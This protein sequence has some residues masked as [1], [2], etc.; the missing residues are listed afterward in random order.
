MRQT[1]RKARKSKGGA[2]GNWF[3]KKNTIKSSLGNLREKLG[4]AS[5]TN[6]QGALRS[7]HINHAEK[8]VVEDFESIADNQNKNLNKSFNDILVEIVRKYTS[9]NLDNISESLDNISEN[10]YQKYNLLDKVKITKR[11][12]SNTK[13]KEG[14][15]VYFIIGINNDVEYKIRTCPKY[16]DSVEIKSAH[17]RWKTGPFDKFLK[18][19]LESFEFNNS[20]KIIKEYLSA[21]DGEIVGRAKSDAKGKKE[22]TVYFI[23]KGMRYE[24]KIR[25]CPDSSYTVEINQDGTWKTGPLDNGFD[26]LIKEKL[27]KF[28]KSL[29]NNG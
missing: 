11:G 18:K 3:K 21:P 1:R 28:E 4:H 22:C 25:T 7:P 17:G 19:V 12:T 8:R 20:L 29:K 16:S 9:K 15:N 6:E 10:T 2:W 24:Y 26:D 27:N 5:E 14:C 13:G 23:G